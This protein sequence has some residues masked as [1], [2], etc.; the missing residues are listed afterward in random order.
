MNGTFLPQILQKVTLYNN[1]CSVMQRF[2]KVTFSYQPANYLEFKLWIITKSKTKTKTVLMEPINSSKT[3][4][5]ALI[6]FFHLVNTKLYYYDFI[7]KDLL[8]LT[9]KSVFKG[10]G[11]V[12]EN[13]VIICKRQ[14]NYFE[15]FFSYTIS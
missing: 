10:L 5:L 9:F 11:R 8:I 14:P 7:F 2:L 1:Y 12:T 6:V 13:F 15:N 3:V 4:I